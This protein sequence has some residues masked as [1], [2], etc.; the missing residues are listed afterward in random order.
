MKTKKKQKQTKKKIS[1]TKYDRGQEGLTQIKFLL[2]TKLCLA[3]RNIF[4]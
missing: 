4:V 1:M 3:T 2:E